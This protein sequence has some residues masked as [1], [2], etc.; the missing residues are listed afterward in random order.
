MPDFRTHFIVTNTDF[1]QKINKKN[2]KSSTENKRCD[3]KMRKND[4]KLEKS[5]KSEVDAE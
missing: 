1:E 4:C 3:V 2:F 5:L